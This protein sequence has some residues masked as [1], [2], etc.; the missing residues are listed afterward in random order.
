[1]TRLTQGKVGSGGN[2]EG[3]ITRGVVTVLADVYCLHAS[4][5][6]ALEVVLMRTAVSRLNRRHCLSVAKCSPLQFGHCLKEAVQVFQPCSPP[7]L[8]HLSFPLQ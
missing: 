5:Y 4:A 1:M 7:Q 2:S 6:V 8:E 3:S